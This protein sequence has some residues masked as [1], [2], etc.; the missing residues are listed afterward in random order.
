MH[1]Q[2]QDLDLLIQGYN[3]GGQV[4]KYIQPQAQT[5]GSPD[6]CEEW[7]LGELAWIP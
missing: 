3:P 5:I 4:N 6:L 7:S 1:A 2:D